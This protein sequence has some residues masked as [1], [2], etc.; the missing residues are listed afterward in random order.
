MSTKNCVVCVRLI[1]RSAFIILQYVCPDHQNMRYC[2][3]KLNGT[4]FLSNTGAII[5]A[6]FI[7]AT[8]IPLYIESTRLNGFNNEITITYDQI[9]DRH[10]SRVRWYKVSAIAAPS[11]SKN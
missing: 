7:G 5:P 4:M 1:I 11:K 6:F 9:A 8:L 2:L 10:Q 3:I